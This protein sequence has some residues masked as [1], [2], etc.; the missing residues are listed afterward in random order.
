MNVDYVEHYGT[1]LSVV[2]A[3]RTFTQNRI[4]EAVQRGYYV[5]EDGKL[6]GPKGQLRCRRYGKQTYPTFSTNWGGRVYGIPAHKLA[7]YCFYGKDAFE[8]G[9]VVRHL[10][11]DVLDIS[12]ENI[13]L[14]SYSDNE[15]DKPAQVRRRSAIAGRRSQGYRAVNRK[16]TEDQADEVREF[17]NNL[18]GR[19]APQGAVKELGEKLGVSRTVLN[20]IKKGA[21][22]ASA[23]Y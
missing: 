23:T 2:N 17:Y 19:K 16:L 6:F 3:A 7:A 5:T 20:K 10:N 18:G 11:A 22:Y 12:R 21:Y 14:G 9:V 13:T 4:V 8:P 15:R 1:D